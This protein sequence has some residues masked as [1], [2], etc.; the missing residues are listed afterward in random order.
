MTQTN[1]KRWLPTS[2]PLISGALASAVVFGLRKLGI[3][4]L[5][6]EANEAVA[7]FVGFITAAI[8]H[9]PSA[10]QVQTFEHAEEATLGSILAREYQSRLDANPDL[11]QKVFNVVA[12][13]TFTS[14]TAATQPGQPR[15]NYGAVGIPPEAQAGMDRLRETHG[16]TSIPAA[17]PTEQGYPAGVNPPTDAPADPVVPTPPTHF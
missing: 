6:Q 7:T 4:V 16:A 11:I 8:V 14:P 15:S 12:S 10:G 5:P 1:W 3:V 13:V 17:I 2:A 9:K